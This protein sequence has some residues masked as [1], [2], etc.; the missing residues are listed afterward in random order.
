MKNLKQNLIDETATEITAKENDI[1]MSDEEL[2]VL[3]ARLKESRF[4]DE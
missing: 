4:I 2:T 3:G 1:K